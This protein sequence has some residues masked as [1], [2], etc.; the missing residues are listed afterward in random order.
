MKNHL[1]T[2]E[3]HPLPTPEHLE[4]SVDRL[5]QKGEFTAAE[6]MLASNT[7]RF[8]RERE[9]YH[10][11]AVKKAALPLYELAEDGAMVDTR[12]RALAARGDISTLLRNELNY[13]RDHLDN[14][15]AMRTS[16]GRMSELTVLDLQTRDLCLDEDAPLLLPT[17]REDDMADTSGRGVDYHLTFAQRS[18]A[19]R[20]PIQV[21][22]KLEPEHRELFLPHINLIGMNELDSEHYGAGAVHTDSLPSILLRDAQGAATPEDLQRIN[23]ATLAF[24]AK[25]KTRVSDGF[26]THPTKTG[27][28]QPA[29]A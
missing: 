14:R 17:F 2:H 12:E 25:I 6:A 20:Y 11:L 8:K 19:D 9:T 18:I 5:I 24:Y 23:E 26:S 28:V 10:R 15:A 22:T 29:A 3:R 21:K 13:L 4:Q 27:W 16:V 1:P 7:Q